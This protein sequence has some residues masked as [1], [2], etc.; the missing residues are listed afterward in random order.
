MS[1]PRAIAL[2]GGIACGKSTALAMF[3]EAGCET[4]DADDLAHD[5]LA[6]G[7]PGPAAVA[8]AFG[9]SFLA[10]DGSV[11]RPK[12]ASL[13]FADP[14]A[15]ARLNA[16]S[17]PAIRARLLA[18]RDAQRAAS[19]L[20]VAAIP[21]LFE[22]GWQSDWDATVCIVSSERAILDRLAARGLTPAQSRARLAA[23]LPLAEKA[24]LATH[25]LPNDST[26]PALRSSVLSLLSALS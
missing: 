5:W 19:R 18:W 1:A 6:A 3:R 15:L 10:P 11:D 2:T 14:G 16:L 12:L 26:L 17:H 20:A 8:D 22:T 9:P 4:V 25:V 24:R 13:V 21:L 23:Q 7:A